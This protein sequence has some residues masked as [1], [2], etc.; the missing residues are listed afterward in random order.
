MNERRSIVTINAR[1]LGMQEFKRL[2]SEIGGEPHEIALQLEHYGGAN[3]VTGYRLYYMLQHARHA[4][5]AHV[6]LLTD[7]AFWIEEAGDWLI[8]SGIDS[9]IVS[10]DQ[11]LDT[12][13]AARIEQF[14]SRPGAP[15]VEMRPSIR[16]HFKHSG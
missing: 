4:G 2:V 13:L 5:I 3:Q 9:L 6:T 10:Y 15:P 8:D 1:A 11:P 12:T 16:H 7:G 14:A